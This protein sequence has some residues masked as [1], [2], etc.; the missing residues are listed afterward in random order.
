M[1]FGLYRFMCTQMQLQEP[2]MDSHGTFSWGAFSNSM[3]AFW[4]IPWECQL[5]QSFVN[6]SKNEVC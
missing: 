3:R 6:A 2:P 1:P 5:G 4:G